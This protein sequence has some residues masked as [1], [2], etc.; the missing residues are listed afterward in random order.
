M[1]KGCHYN[2]VDLSAPT[3]LPPRVRMLSTPYMLLSMYIWIMSCGKDEN[4]Q[5]KP[6]SAHF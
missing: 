5:K 6:E 2:S 4:K 3:I 1:Y